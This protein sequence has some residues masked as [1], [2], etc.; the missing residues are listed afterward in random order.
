VT[1]NSITWRLMPNQ[2]VR[3]TKGPLMRMSG[4]ILVVKPHHAIAE[5]IS[6]ILP[7]E[8]IT[9]DVAHDR[10]GTIASIARQRPALVLLDDHIAALDM[11]GLRAYITRQYRVSIPIIY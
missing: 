7:E 8:G 1:F 9:V 5:M 2:A 10:A 3:D 11:A 6:E 4:A